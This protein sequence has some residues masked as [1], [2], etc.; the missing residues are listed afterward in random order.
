M[1]KCPP[2]LRP[3]QQTLGCA[4][5]RRFVM[6]NFVSLTG[7]WMQRVALGWLIWD[8][9]GSGTWLGIVAAI[10][11]LPAILIS[12][13]GGTLA[14]R[15]RLRGIILL[16]LLG[17]LVS[18]AVLFLLTVIDII[19][20]Y[21]IA[22][23][24]FVNGVMMGIYQ[25]ARM[26]FMARLLPPEDLP[27]GLALNSVTWNL[28]GFVGPLLTGLLIV[29][30]GVSVVF[31]VNVLSY[32]AFICILSCL[33][34][35]R[36]IEGVRSAARPLVRELHEGVRY[37]IRHRGIRLILLLLLACSIGIRPLIDLMPG[38]VGRLSDDGATALAILV[39]SIGMGALAGGIVVACRGAQDLEKELGL[40]PLSAPGLMALAVLGF[41]LVDALWWAALMLV[42]VGGALAITTVSLQAVVQLAVDREM[43]GRVLGLYNMVFSGGPAVGALGMGL[44]SEMVGLEASLAAGAFVVLL[45]WIGVWR[46]RSIVSG[47]LRASRGHQESADP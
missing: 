36:A 27:S 14:D 30:V 17:A 18:S 5:F 7:T 37:T 13:V 35:L 32:A 11:M 22:I 16:T 42:V 19:T 21:Q 43:R 33:R 28:A 40:L 23:I 9:T 4:D 41:I 31:A 6:G 2:Y 44:A 34:S 25:P 10:E 15:Y 46:N 29:H 1:M 12:P 38:L 24:V 39:S 3:I 47:S 45:V 20:P 26:A 8:L